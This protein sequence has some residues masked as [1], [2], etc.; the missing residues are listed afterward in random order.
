[1]IP[2]TVHQAAVAARNSST[3]RTLA[4]QAAWIG[5]FAAVTA[6][7]AQLEIPHQPV[8]YTLQTLAVLLAGGLLGWRN[9]ALSMFLYLAAGIAGAPVFSGA[10]FG[11]IRLLGP[12]GGYLLA[13][14]V[15]A[16]VVGWMVERRQG[17]GW[18]A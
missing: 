10:G 8:P 18:T 17:L 14:P 5:G 12:T 9:G 11:L 13:F 4:T 16:A 3:S 2:M 6:I 7:A 15:A 1:M